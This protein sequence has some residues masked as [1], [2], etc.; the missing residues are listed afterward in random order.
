MST[1]P[2]TPN[3][4]QCAAIRDLLIRPPQED[5][6]FRN[7]PSVGDGLIHEASI[8]AVKFSIPSTPHGD[9]ESRPFA[10]LLENPSALLAVRPDPFLDGAEAARYGLPRDCNPFV[11]P[12]RRKNWFTGFDATRREMK[13]STQAKS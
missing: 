3:E 5:T 6:P 11:L 9:D 8:K 10:Q 4:A 13:T 2:F 12:L 1:D 7:D